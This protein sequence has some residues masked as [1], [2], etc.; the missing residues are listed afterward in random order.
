M[1]F[2]RAPDGRPEIFSKDMT[3]ANRDS[4]KGN[5]AE[6]TWP[7]CFIPNPRWEEGRSRICRV[8]SYGG[9]NAIEVERV[10]RGSKNRNESWMDSFWAVSTKAFVP[11]PITLT[12][13]P[14][15]LCDSAFHKD[16]FNLHIPSAVVK[17]Y[18]SVRLRG[19]QSDRG[20]LKPFFYLEKEKIPT[21]FQ[22]FF[23]HFFKFLIS[24]RLSFYPKLT[25]NLRQQSE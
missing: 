12:L 14:P 21:F 3:L 16:R 8:A 1:D 20:N 11:F 25:S 9:G 10:T 15:A 22:Y 5:C 24:P 4:R 7:S 18:W 13:F 23:F 2:F 19:Q 6:E 17:I